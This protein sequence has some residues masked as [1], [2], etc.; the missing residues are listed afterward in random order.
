LYD[1]FA[2]VFE[3]IYLLYSHDV[4]IISLL[5]SLYCFLPIKKSYYKS[6]HQIV[7]QISLLFQLVFSREMLKIPWDVDT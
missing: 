7:V 6:Y 4:L 3:Q 5:F 2:I 1:Y